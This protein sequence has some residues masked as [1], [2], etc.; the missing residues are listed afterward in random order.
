MRWIAGDGK[1][2]VQVEHLESLSGTDAWHH[3][4]GFVGMPRRLTGFVWSAKHGLRQKLY[5]T[6]AELAEGNTP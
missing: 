3:E 6:A 2:S 5:V 1:H 4:M